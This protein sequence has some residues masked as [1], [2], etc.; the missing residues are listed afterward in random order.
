M[1]KHAEEACT[2]NTARGEKRAENREAKSLRVSEAVSPFRVG[3]S[4]IL[5]T[6]SIYSQLEVWFREG[7]EEHSMNDLHLKTP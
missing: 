7:A 2:E 4:P 3:L 5:Q 6:G 1:P